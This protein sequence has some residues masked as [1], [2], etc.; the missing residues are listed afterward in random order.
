MRKTYSMARLLFI[1]WLVIVNLQFVLSE[2]TAFDAFDDSIHFAIEWR[3]HDT[4][5]GDDYEVYL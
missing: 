1:T 5:L 4:S 3:H 2:N